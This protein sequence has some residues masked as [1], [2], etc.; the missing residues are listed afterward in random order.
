MTELEKAAS[1]LLYDA[2][3]DPALLEARAQ[4]SDL[5]MDYNASVPPQKEEKSP[6]AYHFRCLCARYRH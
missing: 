4:T 1:G 5:C 3:S 6:S 2:N